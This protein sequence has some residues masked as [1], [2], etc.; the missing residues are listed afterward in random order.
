MLLYFELHI[1]TD[2]TKSHLSISDNRFLTRNV[3]TISPFRRPIPL[4]L[5]FS[6]ASFVVLM[7][8]AP[9]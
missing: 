2:V 1:F 8:D 7:G 9:F 6:Y 3:W 4:W 5:T